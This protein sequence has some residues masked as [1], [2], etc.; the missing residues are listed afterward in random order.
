MDA[1]VVL[2]PVVLDPA[3]ELSVVDEPP[4]VPE[5]VVPVEVELDVSSEPFEHPNTKSAAQAPRNRSDRFITNGS[6]QI[7]LDKVKRVEG[8]CRFCEADFNKSSICQVDFDA[9]CALIAKLCL[10]WS[11]RGTDARSVQSTIQTGVRQMPFCVWCQQESDNGS[12]CSWC[13]RP[14]D[15]KPTVFNKKPDFEFLKVEDE[16]IATPYYAIFG[17]FCLAVCLVIGIM[18]SRSKPTVVNSPA[19]QD[20]GWQVQQPDASAS[21]AP[22]YQPRSVATRGGPTLAAPQGNPLVNGSSAGLGRQGFVDPGNDWHVMQTSDFSPTIVADAPGQDISSHA[23]NF[24]VYIQ[25]VHFRLVSSPSG[26]THLIGDIVVINDMLKPFTGSELWLKVNGMKYKLKAFEGSLN[27][28]RWQSTFSIP[29]RESQTFHAVA[30]GL[31]AWGP[32]AASKEIGLDGEVA[33]APVHVEAKI[34]E[35][36]SVPDP[37]QG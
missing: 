1:P 33:G 9:F 3:A 12:V 31:K 10:K 11:C 4:V 35:R 32:G 22:A 24:S 16:G 21:N 36:K 7:T 8:Q 20:V 25:T 14:I 6:T 2:V 23:Q 37:G 18:L 13:K 5:E 27:A 19:S 30:D 28:P 17:V 29:S 26:D 15:D 34:G